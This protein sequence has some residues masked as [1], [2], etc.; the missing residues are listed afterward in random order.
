MAARWI[1][2]IAPALVA[3][4]F[5]SILY[6]PTTDK[7]AATSLIVDDPFAA[8]LSPY[9]DYPPRI[10]VDTR[11]ASSTVAVMPLPRCTR[12]EWWGPLTVWLFLWAPICAALVGTGFVAARHGGVPSFFR[13]GVAAGLAASIALSFFLA[14]VFASSHAM[15][16][17]WP[18]NVLLLISFASALGMLGAAIVK[19][20]A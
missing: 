1:S 4:V 14:A 10:V 16:V 15:P 13:S 12:D 5:I 19:R 17:Q 11:G 6:L 7:C 18:V 3:A 2:V 20:H 9:P 8:L